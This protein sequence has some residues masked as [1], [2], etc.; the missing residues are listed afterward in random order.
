M[1][2]VRVWGGGG[3]Y[4]ALLFPIGPYWSLLAIVQDPTAVFSMPLMWLGAYG[5]YTV[6]SIQ[7]TDISDIHILGVKRFNRQTLGDG[8]TWTMPPT[9][10]PILSATSDEL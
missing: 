1:G 9:D 3:W 6:Y 2:M 10:S 7:Y 5:L 8:M 4:G